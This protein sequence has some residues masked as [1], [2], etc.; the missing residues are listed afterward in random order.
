M[1][2]LEYVLPLCDNATLFAVKFW[3]DDLVTLFDKFPR[4]TQCQYLLIG[5][6]EPKENT[7]EQHMEHLLYWLAESSEGGQAAKTASYRH[8]G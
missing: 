6:D 2:A 3:I 1:T 8:L 4:L 7:V 5:W